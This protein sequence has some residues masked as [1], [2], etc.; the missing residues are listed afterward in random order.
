LNILTSVTF[1][2]WLCCKVKCSK[3][4]TVHKNNMFLWSKQKNNSLFHQKVGLIYYIREMENLEK[5]WYYGII[6]KI[7]DLRPCESPLRYLRFGEESDIKVY[8][9]EATK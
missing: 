8:D 2:F 1:I 4:S 3:N 5:I 6:L 9:E 7:G